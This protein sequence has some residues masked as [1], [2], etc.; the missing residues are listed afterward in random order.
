MCLVVKSGHKSDIMQSLMCYVMAF[1]SM[2]RVEFRRRR[3]CDCVRTIETNRGV[4]IETCWVECLERAFR[5][6][7][8][9][10]TKIE[11]EKEIWNDG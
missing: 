2:Q 10:E 11:I 1:I 3:L 4:R 5:R 8:E 7:D 6:T 9:R